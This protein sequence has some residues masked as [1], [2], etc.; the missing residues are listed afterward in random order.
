MSSIY[1]PLG[2]IV[3]SKWKRIAIRYTAWLLRLALVTVKRSAHNIS[4]VEK[5]IKTAFLSNV[6]PKFPFLSRI[7]IAIDKR[8]RI[9][10]SNVI[11]RVI[12]CQHS[13]MCQNF[14][15]LICFDMHVCIFYAPPI[16]AVCS[17]HNQFI[18][19]ISLF[20][21]IFDTPIRCTLWFNKLLL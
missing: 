8:V 16:N 19:S 18:N 7:S 1:N 20:S 14:D 12:V 2:H 9:R 5:F 11:F 21:K 6:S 4:I 17:I 10:L 3:L 13:I 15:I